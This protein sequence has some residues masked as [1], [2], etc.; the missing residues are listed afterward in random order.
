ML[1]FPSSLFIIFILLSKQRIYKDRANMYK[2]KYE[3]GNKLDYKL[4]LLKLLNMSTTVRDARRRNEVQNI[5]HNNNIQYKKTDNYIEFY[6]NDRV[7]KYKSTTNRL[8]DVLEQMW[9]R[10]G[11]MM[12]YNMFNKQ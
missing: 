9:H 11:L 6:F 1:Y 3:D 4:K 10:E 8:L 7:Y 12:L 2:K 5:L